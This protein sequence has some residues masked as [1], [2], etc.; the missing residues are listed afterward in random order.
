MTMSAV[1]TWCRACGLP[2]AGG[3]CG[4]CGAPITPP[5]RPARSRVGLV[6]EQRR[7]MR[8]SRRV[9]CTSDSGR[10]LTVHV[11][12]QEDLTL[13][14]DELG[15]PLDVVPDGL[16]TAGRLVH[17][18][19]SSTELRTSWDSAA[20]TARAGQI[21]SSSVEERRALANDALRLGWADVFEQVGLTVTE[22]A[23]LRAHEAAAHARL[24]DLRRALEQLPDASYTVKVGLVLP[25]LREVAADPRDWL[26]L[27]Q[28]W[29]VAGVAGAADLCALV[30]PDWRSAVA[31][32]LDALGRSG[33]A[34]EPTLRRAADELQAGRVPGPPAPGLPAWEAAWAYQRG[35]SG[36]SVD[37]ELDVVAALALPL[38]DDLVDVGA[39]TGR[40][41]VRAMSG[42]ARAHLLARLAPQSLDDATLEALGHDGERAR[43]RFLQRDAP[44][45]RS[46]PDTQ[47]TRHFA[48]LLDVVQ[49]REPDGERLRPQAA[50]LL[51]VVASTREALRRGV[52]T[53]LPD[54]VLRDPTLWPVVAE[55]VRT[56]AVQPDE[57]ARQEHPAFAQWCD[58]QRLLGLVWEGRWSD[59]EQLGRTLAASSALE[60][61]QDEALNLA[62][63][64]LLQQGRLGEALGLLERALDGSYTDALLVNASIVAS[65][66]DPGVAT[67]FL[68]KLVREAPSAEMRVAALARAVSAWG[69]LPDGTPFPPT[70]EAP[71]AETLA[72]E[73]Q[74]DDYVRFLRVAATQIPHVVRRLTTQDHDKQGVLALRQAVIRFRED[75]DFSHGDL[76]REFVRLY[77]RH[78]RPDWF[79]VDFRAA[80]DVFNEHTFVD[81]GDAL[82]PALFWDAICAEEPSLLT[83]FDRLVLL[84]QAGAHFAAYLGTRQDWLSDVQLQRYFFDTTQELLGSGDAFPDEVRGYLA[85][86]LGKCMTLAALHMLSESREALAGAYND[87]VAR[88][89]WDSANRYAI[90]SQMLSNLALCDEVADRLDRVVERLHRLPLTVDRRMEWLDAI[91]PETRDW[92][93]EVGRL[94][95]QL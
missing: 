59:A 20:L 80:V 17:A 30:G 13:P 24:D 37:G 6:F 70:L 4:T 61:Q 18:A 5:A 83:P 62:A 47:D 87:L 85:D 51:R 27:L 16:S 78:G 88:L 58:L 55:Q 23:W 9:V 26:P 57:A 86:N 66:T 53:S 7:R 84:P 75:D 29:A 33:A 28:R 40:A 94:R 12:A 60:R 43:R 71:L 38:L 74:L 81:F 41:P 64:A 14:A 10:E 50:Q 49:G 65:E 45:L 39:L 68:A 77:R 67:T 91:G 95:A 56:G 32:G 48:A 54:A 76:A 69:A 63:F 79:D 89:R 35:M 44:G 46:L 1:A 22:R 15:Q 8:P 72:G 11:A 82:G 34:D 21:V 25:Y 93:N 3:A 31:A 90:R 42:P 36:A 2:S 73:C 52:A 19:R 92:R